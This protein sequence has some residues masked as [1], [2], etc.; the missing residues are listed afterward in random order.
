MKKHDTLRK[1]EDQLSDILA[2]IRADNNAIK[3]EIANVE[4]EI[5]EVRRRIAH[6][7]RRSNEPESDVLLKFEPTHAAPPRLQ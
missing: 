2:K 6:I 3:S 1:L 4:R 5:A 7:E